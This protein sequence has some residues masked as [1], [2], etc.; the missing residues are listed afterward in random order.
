MAKG[1][2]QMRTQADIQRFQKT[3]ASYRSMAKTTIANAPSGSKAY[4]EAIK[5]FL[6]CD[7]AIEAMNWILDV[8]EVTSFGPPPIVTQRQKG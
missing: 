5:V 7:G 3:L 1:G 8:G 6:R 2:N 4:T